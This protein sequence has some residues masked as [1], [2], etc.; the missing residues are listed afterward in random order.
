MTYATGSNAAGNDGDCF[1]FPWVKFI[2]YPYKSHQIYYS[3][4]S[5]NTP[6]PPAVDA[7]RSVLLN[8]FLKWNFEKQLPSMQGQ[9][10]KQIH[11]FRFP[12][13]P[14]GILFRA[15]LHHQHE[16]VVSAG[17]KMENPIGITLLF[18]FVR[19][20]AYEETMNVFLKERIGIIN[21]YEK[22]WCRNFFFFFQ[23]KSIWSWT[24]AIQFQ[25]WS[26]HFPVSLSAS[27]KCTVTIEKSK[28]ESL[29]SLNPDAVSITP[30]R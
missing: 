1:F 20:P 11:C 7:S 12:L 24:E 19:F 16:A 22:S 26:F 15:E 21:S 27:V 4:F 30:W 6:Y 25:L 23:D 10:W 8:Q 2:F 5:K 3:A 18:F 9:K 17:W 28:L 14:S 13:N 29:F